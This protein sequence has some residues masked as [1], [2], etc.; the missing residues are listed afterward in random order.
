MNAC[1]RTDALER[2]LASGSPATGA[3]VEHARGCASCAATIAAATRLQTD[4]PRVVATMADEPLPGAAELLAVR[5]RRSGWPILRMAAPVAIVVAVVMAIA[6]GVVGGRFIGVTGPAPGTGGGWTG[7]PSA[8]ELAGDVPDDMAAWV[9]EADASIWAHLDRP[10][11]APDLH[12]VRLER[13]G[14]IALAFFADPLPSDAGPLLFGLGNYRQAPF[15][16]GFGGVATS[17]DDT[18]AANARSQQPEP[19]EVVVDT[20]L[21]PDVALAAYLAFLADNDRVTD[22]RVLATKLVTDEIALAYVDEIE[23][24]T[25]QPHQQ[26]LVLRRSSDA[27]AV[28]GAQGGDYPVVGSVVGV[29]PLGVAKSMP[30]ERWAAVGRTEDARVVA[31]ELDF[32]GFTH[33]F[34]VGGGA[35]VILLPPDAGFE[36]PYRLLDADGGIVSEAVSQP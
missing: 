20:V 22:P 17:V 23:T 5:E 33:R 36:L 34:P 9:A 24:E 35:F 32:A 6:V 28:T 29:T 18:E 19:C 15:E 7:L 2:R 25:G 3:D 14:D 31:V 27:W 21:S 26:V 11:L 13:C 10:L 8:S 1:R 16:A 30:D 12:L 4:L